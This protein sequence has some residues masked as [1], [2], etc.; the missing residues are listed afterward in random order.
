MRT[1]NEGYGKRLVETTTAIIIIGSPIATWATSLAVG[2]TA[3]FLYPHLPDGKEWEYMVASWVV[4][5]PLLT[6]AGFFLAVKLVNMFLVSA[7]MNP[8][9]PP[10]KPPQNSYWTRVYNE[11]KLTNVI[12]NNEDD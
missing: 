10:K 6:V 11:N 5:V 7:G 8:P 2:L 1:A 4:L 3:V 9:T 12:I